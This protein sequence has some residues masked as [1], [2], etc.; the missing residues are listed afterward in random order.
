MSVLSNAGLLLGF[1]A[2]VYFIVNYVRRQFLGFSIHYL[3][4]STT[5]MWNISR[6]YFKNTCNET[7]SHAMKSHNMKWHNI[8]VKDKPTSQ[9]T[10]ACWRLCQY[11]LQVFSAVLQL[12]QKSN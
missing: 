7:I 2:C 8:C 11:I 9:N 12:C 5:R 10:D 3:D 4:V 6:D 1:F